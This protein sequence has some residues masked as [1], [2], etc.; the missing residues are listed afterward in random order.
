MRAGFEVVFGVGAEDGYRFEGHCTAV[1]GGVPWSLGY[2]ITVDAEWVTRRAEISELSDRGARRAVLEHDGAGHWLVDGVAAPALDGC[3]DADL[4]ASAFTNAIP[5]GR[6][7]LEGGETGRSAGVWLRSPGCEVERLEQ[8]YLRIPD[9]DGLSRY[10]YSAPQ[11]RFEAELSYDSAGVG[12][13]YPGLA[14]RVL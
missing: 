14:T 6:L 8:T 11:L 13:D 10:R 7:G 4:E 1:E 5:V 3:L 12:T 2:L 9:A